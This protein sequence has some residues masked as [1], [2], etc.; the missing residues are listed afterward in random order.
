[1]LERPPDDISPT[2]LARLS[3]ERFIREGA[4][5][6]P[7]DS[8]IGI[9]AERAGAFVTLRDTQGDL[10]GCIGTIEPAC[11][12]VAEEIIHNAISAATRDPRFSPVTAGELSR[13]VYGVDV[14]SQTEPAR[15]PDDLDPSVYGVIIEAT[16]DHR[17]AVLLPRIEGIETVDEQ[18]NAVHQKAGLRIGDHVRVLRF[19]VKRFGKD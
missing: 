4:E 3:V 16:E 1:M 7:P 11:L 5:I 9:L 8:P 17:R 15:G 13:I 2:A 18:W 10:R 19:T 14:L 6:S 12:N